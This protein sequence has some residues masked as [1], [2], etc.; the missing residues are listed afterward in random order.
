MQAVEDRDMETLERL[1]G[2][3]DDALGAGRA[4]AVATYLR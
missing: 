4:R 1:A 2:F 3:H